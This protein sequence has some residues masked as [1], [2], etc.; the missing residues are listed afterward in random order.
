MH[1]IK[2]YVPD[3]GFFLF[4]LFIITCGLGGEDGSGGFLNFLNVTTK[5]RK[6]SLSA[7]IVLEG[8]TK[9]SN[10]LVIYYPKILFKDSVQLFRCL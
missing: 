3:P 1:G 7:K 5:Q 10:D 4:L 9:K 2:H 6:L 8:H